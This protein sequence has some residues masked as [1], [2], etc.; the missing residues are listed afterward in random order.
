[1]PRL[2]KG[3]KWTFGW[4]EICQDGRLPIPPEAWIEYGF[5]SNDAFIVI[6]ASR[7]SG[8]FGVTTREHIKASLHIKPLASLS[9]VTK[10]ILKLPETLFEIIEIQVGAR[11]LTVRGSRY[12]LGCIAKGPIIHEAYNHPELEIFTIES[13]SRKMIHLSEEN[14][15]C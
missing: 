11:L 15:G 12:A 9:I 14:E 1:M 8:G 10:G 13:Y 7:T 4:V 2:V 6:P 5:T 3:G